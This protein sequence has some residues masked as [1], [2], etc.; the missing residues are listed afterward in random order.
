MS[1]VLKKTDAALKELGTTVDATSAKVEAA[2]KKTASFGTAATKIDAAA[3]KA[4]MGL[5][6]FSQAASAV[7][8]DVSGTLGPMASAADAMGDLA[9]T[10]QDLGRGAL[11]IGI[12]VT[13]FAALNNIMLERN[14]AIADTILKEDEWAKALERSSQGSKLAA[15]GLR[16]YAE[17]QAQVQTGWSWDI[18][19]VTERWM[20]L[21]MVGRGAAQ[22]LHMVG[23]EARD[24]APWLETSAQKAE[25]LKDQL[26]AMVFAA[27]AAGEQL[28]TLQ[29]IAAADEGGRGKGGTGTDGK[30]P[31]PRY[32]THRKQLD[33]LRATAERTASALRS[34]VEG[35]LSPTTVETRL[36]M[37]GDAWDEFR[38]RL[39]A[40]ATGSP[41]TQYGTE[42]AAQLDALGMSAEAAAVAFKNFSLFANPDNIK[43][44]NMG[45]LVDTV[46]QQLD[47]MIGKANLTSAAMAE[48]WKNLS[49][50]QKAVLAANGIDTAAE[51]ITALEDPTAKTKTQVEG[52]G[53]ALSGIPRTVTSTVNVVKDAATLAIE[54]FRSVLDQFI[55]DYGSVTVSI[56]AEANAGTPPLPDTPPPPS[57]GALPNGMNFA[58]GLDWTVPGGFPNDTY[59]FR[60]N[61]TSGE[62][63]QITP[64][65]QPAANL[66]PIFNI[67]IDGER[68]RGAKVRML[69]AHGQFGH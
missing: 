28:K 34:I 25:R 24:L 30:A 52:L 5:R 68:V 2:G 12:L 8:I 31:P 53:A 60:G 9:K 62:R 35:A 61:L 1:A 16:E 39:E 7:G 36:G 47:S 23:L 29:G 51:A 26:N 45:P 40:V 15:A 57:T 55:A 41:P 4:S 64:A 38:L 67:Y 65:G 44:V 22:A 20:Q 6:A 59:P 27:G 3:S 32:E 49:P 43:L 54:A 11:G 21:D 58:R 46:K 13:A 48:V 63:V 37:A 14:H 50:Q 66:A 17:A 33:A 56:N 10:A 42:F 69:E 19:D 18:G